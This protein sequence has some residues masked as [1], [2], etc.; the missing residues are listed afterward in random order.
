MET[1]GLIVVRFKMVLIQIWQSHRSLMV[2]A[3]VSGL[4]GP[5][6]SSAEGIVFLG[7]TLTVT[8]TVPLSALGE[9]QFHPVGSNR[10]KLWPDELPSFYA[11]WM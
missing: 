5:G 9:H 8:L 7:K 10:D 6:L 3:F 2:S 11:P 1:L 4:S